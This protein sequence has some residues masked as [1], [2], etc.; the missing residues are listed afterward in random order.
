[1]TIAVAGGTVELRRATAADLAALVAL[2]A[3]DELGARREAT[4]EDLTPYR[5][6]FDLVDADAAHLLVAAVLGEAI[7]G[8][9]QLS[10]LPGLSRR[11]ALRAQIEAV[12]VALSV[13]SGGVGAAM[14]GWAVEEAGRRGCALV[15][16][17]TDKSRGDAHRFYE[18]LGFE[19]THEGLKLQLPAPR[20]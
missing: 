17:M 12:R 7:V 18:R 2:L 14:V 8:T 11:G 20:G 15:Q 19:A 4:D 9:L 5:T 16:L 13:R 3:D 1:V 6:A 10:F